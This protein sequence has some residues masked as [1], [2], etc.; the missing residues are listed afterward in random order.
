MLGEFMAYL[1]D[2]AELEFLRVDCFC[3]S[4]ALPI[5]FKLTKACRSVNA[6]PETLTEFEA[7]RYR[8]FI[9]LNMSE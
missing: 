2:G 9:A 8:Q 1:A 5:L 6:D 3:V 4:S 7:G